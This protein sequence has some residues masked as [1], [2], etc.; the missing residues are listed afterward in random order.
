V[1]RTLFSIWITNAFCV[2]NMVKHALNILW[3]SHKNESKK[4]NIMIIFY[5]YFVQNETTTLNQE[6]WMKVSWKKK[7]KKTSYFL[8]N[9]L[10]SYY[11]CSWILNI[12]F[13]RMC[14]SF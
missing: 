2:C 7:K 3:W 14:P 13:Q 4:W 5:V 10:M 12:N 8:K 11:I 6:K 9:F 1:L